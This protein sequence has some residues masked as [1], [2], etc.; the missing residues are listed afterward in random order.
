[1]GEPKDSPVRHR[2]SVASENSPRTSPPR[3]ESGDSLESDEKKKAHPVSGLLQRKITVSISL[4]S[5]LILG[6][7]A[8]L[9]FYVRELEDPLEALSDT[10]PSFVEGT[11]RSQ[12]A[13]ITTAKN[14]SSSSSQQVV[15]Q[16]Q[17][18]DALDH[19]TC[20]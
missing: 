20:T 1:M 8:F 14:A 9:V 2:S 19:G 6:L 15:E 17:N 11:G 13:Q 10:M 5:I 18:P 12:R 3:A 7:C 4:R 16:V